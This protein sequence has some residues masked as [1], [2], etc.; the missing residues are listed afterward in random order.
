MYTNNTNNQYTKLPKLTQRQMEKMPAPGFARHTSKLND[1]GGKQ[2][3]KPEVLAKNMPTR[4][5]RMTSGTGDAYPVP[6]RELAKPTARSHLQTSRLLPPKH[7]QISAQ[8][9]RTSS[10]ISNGS[11]THSRTRYTRLASEGAVCTMETAGPKTSDSNTMLTS[12]LTVERDINDSLVAEMKEMAS[13]AEERATRQQGI[14]DD[15]RKENQMLKEQ[16]ASGQCVIEEQRADIQELKR[17]VD[18]NQHELDEQREENWVLQNK[19]AGLQSESQW[20]KVSNFTGISSLPSPMDEHNEVPD[21]DIY[22]ASDDDA[23]ASS[24]QEPVMDG[25][26]GYFSGRMTPDIGAAYDTC[27]R[28]GV[29]DCDD[30]G[31]EC[32]WN[33][34]EQCHS[35]HSGSD[36]SMCKELQPIILEDYGDELLAQ[37]VAVPAVDGG[38]PVFSNDLA[39]GD[40]DHFTLPDTVPA[41]DDKLSV[42][43]DAVA[44]DY[45]DLSAQPDIIPDSNDRI[46]VQLD[47]VAAGDDDLFVQPD[48][49]ADG[50]EKISVQ[51]DTI[52]AGDD[53]LF[54]QPD[55]IADGDDEVSVQLDTGAA[56][57][58]NLSAQPDVIADGGNELPAHL[59]VSHTDARICRR[60]SSPIFA[61]YSRFSD[62]ARLDAT[63]AH[64]SFSHLGEKPYILDP[65][66]P[67]NGDNDYKEVVDFAR[68]KQVL[69]FVR[70]LLLGNDDYQKASDKVCDSLE[71]IDEKSNEMAR[72]FQCGRERR[73]EIRHRKLYDAV[74]VVARK[75]AQLEAQHR[76]SYI[77]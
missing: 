32:G 3:A 53:D 5:P 74:A 20:Q 24:S 22:L 69:E 7:P 4:A 46:S 56:G 51:L 14:L 70:P 37:F 63:L 65:C 55:V 38:L 59:V 15:M 27:D 66:D 77:V 44:A 75:R 25:H 33:I 68:R 71:V 57:D 60:R 73:H 1:I 72:A 62:G 45:D 19:I 47:T 2:R 6:R 52:A 11:Q 10:N 54:A 35:L 26:L 21:E 48:V 36:G 50:D 30:E 61:P 31:I 29:L 17:Q 64:G 34:A 67:L 9:A 58:E 16:I 18:C 28:T 23:R 43:S 76:A 39:A 42:Q 41:D 12:Q 40:D 49:I 8:T 13:M